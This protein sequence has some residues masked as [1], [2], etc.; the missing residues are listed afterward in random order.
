M[1]YKNLK[2]EI[3]DAIAKITLLPPENR[4][5]PTLDQQTG[6]E[7]LAAIEECEQ[8]EKVRVLIIT[9]TGKAFSA[10]GDIKKF[11]ESI[12]SGKAGE[13]MDELTRDLYQIAYKLKTLRIPVIAAVNGFA[14]GA[15]MNLALSCDLIIA[16][17]NAKFAESFINLALIPGFAGTYYLPKLLPWPKVA[18]ICFFGEMISAAEMEKLGLVN[19]VVPLEDLEKV[20]SEYAK[21][22][23]NQPTLAIGRM[24]KL[25]LEGF[26]KDF[27]TA[28]EDERIIQIKSA[29]TEDYKEG[30]F[31]LNEK[32]KPLFKGK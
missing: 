18:E 17:E 10:G 5:F 22:L 20:A 30:V 12:E 6:K 14:V 15:G 24:K 2:L 27:Q 11:K 28:I 16:S 26:N 7:L 8:L 13:F 29:E 19:K 3:S 23:A 9:G 21:K 25:F 31:A 4:K 1:N 32:R